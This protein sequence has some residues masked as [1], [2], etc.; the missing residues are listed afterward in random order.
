L[1]FSLTDMA[2]LIDLEYLVGHEFGGVYIFSNSPAYDDEQRVD[3]LRL[4]NWTQHLGLT[5]IGLQP[6]RNMIGQV[7]AMDVQPGFHA[8]GHAGGGELKEFVRRIS[9]RALIPIHTEAP[10]SWPQLL[11]GQSVRIASPRYAQAMSIDCPEW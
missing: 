11:V 2:D 3:L 8:S 4:W 10:Q 1:A 6:R 7:M 5:L 9:P